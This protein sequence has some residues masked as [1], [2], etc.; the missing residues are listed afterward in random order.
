MGPKK[1][2]IALITWTLT[3]SCSA[4]AQTKNKDPLF[5]QGK[6]Y[7]SAGDL[8]RALSCF[9]QYE[10]IQPNN[11]AVHFYIGLILD[12]TGDSKAAV[13]EYNQCLAQASSIGTDSA[14]LRI[15]MANAQA[16]LGLSKE[17]LFNYQRAIVI[18]A[19]N[20]LAYLG[21]SKCLIDTGDFDG[22]LKAVDRYV[23][24]SQPRTDLSVSLI[25]GLALA[26]QAKLGEARAQLQ[27][28]INTSQ[29]GSQA[30][31][32]ALTQLAVKILSEIEIMQ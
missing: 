24:L 15:N 32:P 29:A 12:Q 31:N 27:L 26:G 28:F 7:F 2:V 23:S 10:A 20:P 14:E 1:V 5:A 13:A 6:D 11:L 30:S 3:F 16:K 8:N 18:D 19:L 9:R 25:R 4:L 21:L 17:A 22:A